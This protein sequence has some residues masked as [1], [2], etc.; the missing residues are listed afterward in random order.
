[1][2]KIES[3]RK[4]SLIYFDT[5]SL[6]YHWKLT[7]IEIESGHHLGQ[8][9][10]EILADHG[11]GSS[12]KEFVTCGPKNYAYNVQQA[13]EII[14]SKIKTKG[15]TLNKWTLQFINYDFMIDAKKRYADKESE[16]RPAKVQQFNIIVNSH[17]NLITKYFHRAY[18]VVPRKRIA[19][20][21]I[22]FPYGFEGDWSIY[23]SGQ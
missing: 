11:L 10:D 6:V 8:L 2:E 13:D 20:K 9:K 4:G 14:K 21:N 16:E 15:I 19:G 18:R 23:A 1:M 7:D 22:T 12:I 5:K 3:I 17:H